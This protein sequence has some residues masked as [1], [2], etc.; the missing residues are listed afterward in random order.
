M[1][2]DTSKSCADACNGKCCIGDKA[3]NMFT[4]KVCLDG[5]CNGTSACD[6]ATVTNMVFASCIGASACSGAGSY[7][8]TVSGRIDSIG[9]SCNMEK[10]CFNLAYYMG[11]KNQR[12]ALSGSCNGN[13]AC[14]YLGKYGELGNVIN[15]CNNSTACETG[16]QGYLMASK[17][18]F[19]SI[20]GGIENSCNAQSACKYAGSVFPGFTGGISTKMSNC[21]NNILN[22]C[23]SAQQATLP[24]QCVPTP[25]PSNTVSTH[26]L[27]P[28]S[29]LLIFFYCSSLCF[30][31]SIV[32]L[33]YSSTTQTTVV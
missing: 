6:N 3:C 21:C 10:A 4:G 27:L 12:V 15:S 5:S 13:S 24:A 22:E 19:G 33:F 30:L 9:N 14:A 1:R 28:G 7:S 31:S 16:G 8:A 23:S 29:S 25:A 2:T 26:H 17:I 11:S 18:V 32:L 20:S